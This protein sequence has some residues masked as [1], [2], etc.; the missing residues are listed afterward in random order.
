M[1]TKGSFL[2][3]V[4]PNGSGKS[5]LLNLIR[6]YKTTKRGNNLFGK[7]INQFRDRE[8][9]G[10]VSQKAN[11][12]NTGFPAMVYEVVKS[13]LTKKIGYFTI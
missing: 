1:I 7:D 10:F 8:N 3:I 4:G 6:I 13:G 11:F 9:I 12:F 2:A 5:T